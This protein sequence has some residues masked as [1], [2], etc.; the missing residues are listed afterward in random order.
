MII[1]Q[2]A[3]WRRKEISRL[4]TG[5][6]AKAFRFGSFS[7]PAGALLLFKNTQISLSVCLFVYIYVGIGLPL[8][9][10]FGVEYSVE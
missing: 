4:C 1:S 6:T 8:T 9:S 7:H 2:S 10:S 3:W 5:Q